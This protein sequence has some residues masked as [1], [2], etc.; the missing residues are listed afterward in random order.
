MDAKPLN[1]QKI[2]NRHMGKLLTLCD[3][4]GMSEEQKFL[5]KERYYFMRDDVKDFYETGGN[6]NHEESYNK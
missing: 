5:I 3:A 1:S 6:E 4:F 2:F